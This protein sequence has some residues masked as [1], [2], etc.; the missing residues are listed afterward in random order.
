MLEIFKRTKI[1]DWEILLLKNVLK[2]LPAEFKTLAEQIDA[3]LLSGILT[4]PDAAPGYVG[5]SYNQKVFSRLKIENESNY[6]ITGIKVYDKRSRSQLLYTIH[7]SCGVI[8]GYSIKGAARFL[9][10]TDK[11]DVSWFIRVFQE[12]ADVGKK[13][14]VIN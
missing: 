12:H 7:V 13:I 4:A 5:F 2:Q 14:T 9:L 10:D 6:K 8:H 11:T 3:G 1:R